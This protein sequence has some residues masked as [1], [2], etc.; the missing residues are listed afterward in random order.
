MNE[1]K[2]ERKGSKEEKE[3]GRE[4]TISSNTVNIRLLSLSSVEHQFQV[5]HFSTIYY[6]HCGL[7]VHKLKIMISNI[8]VGRY[9]LKIR[10]MSFAHE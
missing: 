2:K 3:G 9:D 5:P 4:E 1:G 10:V 6:G 7:V 8:K